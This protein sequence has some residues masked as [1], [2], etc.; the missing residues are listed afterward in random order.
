[1]ISGAGIRPRA[2]IHGSCSVCLLPETRCNMQRLSLLLGAALLISLGCTSPRVVPPAHLHAYSLSQSD[3]DFACALARYSAG[4]A[5][6]INAGPQSS[7][8]VD[9][10]LDAA[11]HDP[12]NYPLARKA[13]T[14]LMYRRRAPDAAA[15]LE[16][17][18]SLNPTNYPVLL[19]LATVYDIGDM[20][21]KQFETY[22]RA[23]ALAPTNAAA[24]VA[25]ARSH[26]GAGKFDEALKVLSRGCKQSDEGLMADLAL[27]NAAALL[28][29][30]FAVQ[31]VE[32]F[33]FVAEH[34]SSSR[35]RMHMIIAEIY[36]ARGD[37]NKTLEHY[38]LAVRENDAASDAYVKM[39]IITG[40]T[41]PKSALK[42]LESAEQR[43]PMNE[44]ILTAVTYLA[45]N[46]N[47]RSDAI[48]L[49]NT[50]AGRSKVTMPAFFFLQLGAVYEQNGNFDKSA[51]TFQKGLESYP[52]SHDILNYLAYMWAEQGLNLE[53]CE[54]MAQR[55]LALEPEN[56]AYLDTLG[57]IYYKKG[58]NEKALANLRK[59]LKYIPEDAT[60][61][62]HLGDV[63]ARQGNIKEAIAE[64]NRSL[65]ID[66]SNKQLDAKIKQHTGPENK[67]G[68]K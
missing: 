39:A 10:F 38:E 20:P 40:D 53:E 51:E 17:T 58:D 54:A 50:F 24:Y 5:E 12:S 49:F 41:D 30:G 35:G 65:T 31:S 27:I 36:E 21:E 59:A 45:R 64:W 37:R 14:G 7:K 2:G 4:I 61:I 48:S 67:A 43:F 23:M 18:S 32:W 13:A 19:D 29:G 60:I 34:S 1:M 16:K 47:L 68:N 33:E 66:P 15:L 57:W 3:L 55:A 11:E 25:A 8:A 46:S 52:D 6:E 63:L 26:L 9:F 42:I 62:E 56:G 44:M 28:K 22:E